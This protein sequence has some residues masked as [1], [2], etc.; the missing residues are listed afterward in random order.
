MPPP[1]AKSGFPPPP[2]PRIFDAIE[3]SIEEHED[4]TLSGGVRVLAERGLA[5]V[6][7]I[8]GKFW[9]DIDDPDDHEIAEA[10]LKRLD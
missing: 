10:Q 7:E 3:T 9:L 4:G 2:P 8:G 1:W 5:Q 6:H